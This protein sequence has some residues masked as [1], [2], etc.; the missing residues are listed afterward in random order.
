MD[1]YQNDFGPFDGKIWL[2][3]ASEG[4]LPKAAV[5]ALKE[6]MEWKV[7]PY[8]LTH[9]RFAQVPEQLKKVIGQLLNVPAEEIILGNS[10]TYGIHLFANGIPL[11]KGEEVLLMQNDFP[12]DILPWLGLQSK[13][14]LIRQIKPKG[15]VLTPEEIAKN[16]TKSTRVVCLPHVHT[17]SGHVLDIKKIGEL[18]R[19]RKIIF[20]VNFSQ[21][22]GTMPV[23]LAKL[24]V[25]GMT[26][27]GFKWLC[28]PYGTG[29]CW[30]R[31]EL[32]SSLQYNQMFWVNVLSPE[33]LQ[34]TEELRLPAKNGARQYDVFGT[35]NFFNFR[36]LT[37]AIEYLLTIGIDK[38][39]D[40]N[41]ELVEKIISGLDPAKYQLLSP[42][43]EGERSMLVVFS[44]KDKLR[45]K[46]IFQFLLTQGMYL[47]LWKGNL[48]ASAHIYNTQE[49]I[50][51]LLNVL[52]NL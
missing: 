40:H 22:L 23:D 7:R 2:N 51:K 6:A 14:V 34:S 37:A 39:Y 41:K 32:L 11:Q 13:G 50:H 3:C 10:A 26:T 17:F 42:Q 5:D 18:C 48:R 36:P 21:S 12:V 29:F 38:I 24:P 43:R 30:L 47:A 31:P 28:G 44:H 19:A 1:L 45:N 15:Y 16:I 9:R 25:D 20:I 46:D 35:A 8:E 49:D 27:A 4:P 33:A 52:N